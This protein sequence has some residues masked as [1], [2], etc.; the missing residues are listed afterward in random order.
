MHGRARGRR[1][2]EDLQRYP[3]VRGFG[4]GHLALDDRAGSARALDLLARGLGEAVRAHGE[5]L[6][7]L[8][9]PEDLHGDALPRG[10]TARGEGHG[11]DLVA[12]AEARVEVAEVNRL[13]MRTELLE[14]HRLLHV[15]AA[16][17]AEPHVDRHLP[18]LGCRP[19]PVAAAGARAVLAPAGCL[20][21]AR[22][23]A[24]ADALLGV[25][26]TGRGLEAVQADLLAHQRSTFTRWLTVAIAPRTAG[27]SGRS[28][29]RPMRPSP[30]VRNVS[31]CFG[32]A[33]LTERSWVIRSLSAISRRLRGHRSRLGGLRGLRGVRCWR[34]RVGRL[35]TLA[36][37]V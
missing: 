25:P 4:I 20:S 34:L 30:S 21:D 5:L 35:A 22:A 10:E 31:R 3:W 18:T 29:L 15:R 12:V 37:A 13:G 7:E 2:S 27:S 14:R 17:L 16:Q 11:R 9:L 32:F 24:A 33:P 36:G 1:P 23:L 8:P 26:R 28:T 19:R 6:G